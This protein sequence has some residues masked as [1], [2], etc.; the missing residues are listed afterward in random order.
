[1]PKDT[2]DIVLASASPRRSEMLAKLGMAFQVV[3]SNADETVLPNESAEDH[4]IRLSR[5]KALEV[6]RRAGQ[7]GRWF[8]GSDTVVVC[9]QLI[10][11]KPGDASEAQAMLSSLSG[12]SHRVISGYAVHDRDKDRTIS[13][14]VTTKVFFKELTSREIE[15]YIASGEPFDKAGSYAIQGIGSFMVPKIEGS[16]TNVVGLPLCEVIA[17][18]EE[19]GAMELFE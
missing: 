16:Y 15:G 2:Q 8:I 19:L 13:A 3:P 4:V 1:M 18:L 6:A 14:A 11:G 10:L 17:A 12:R 7:S 9:D 5:T